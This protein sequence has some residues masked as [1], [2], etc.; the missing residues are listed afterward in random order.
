MRMRLR[1]CPEGMG[2][3]ERPMAM[4]EARSADNCATD[5]FARLLDR[6]LDLEPLRHA[7]GDRR[8]QRAAGAVGMAAVYP[9][10]LPDAQAGSGSEH[11]VNRA[12]GEVATLQQ[13]FGSTELAQLL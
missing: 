12:A 8:G 2:M 5:V 9:R 3:V 10:A 4:P 7:G 13:G 6:G 1:L 11:V